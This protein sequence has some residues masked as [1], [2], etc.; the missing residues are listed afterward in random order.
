MIVTV[1]SENKWD[2]F[3]GIYYEYGALVLIYSIPEIATKVFNILQESTY[4]DKQLLPLLLPNIQVSGSILN[5]GNFYSRLLT[6][7]SNNCKKLY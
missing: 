7:Y 5:V 4:D 2:R 3:D 1:S 6:K